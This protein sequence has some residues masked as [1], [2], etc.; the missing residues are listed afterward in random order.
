LVA[1]T[2]RYAG[3]TVEVAYQREGKREKTEVTLNQPR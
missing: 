3:K 1:A 2:K